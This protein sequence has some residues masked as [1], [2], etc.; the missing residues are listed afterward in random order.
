MKI[1]KIFALALL[2]EILLIIIFFT[3]CITVGFTIVDK[4]LEEEW[5]IHKP[6]NLTYRSDIV[7]SKNY[8]TITVGNTKYVPYREYNTEEYIPADVKLYGAINEGETVDDNI[9]SEDFDIVYTSEICPDYIWLM[10]SKTIENKSVFI[11]PGYL[12]MYVKKEIK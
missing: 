12:Q 3:A 10:S 6:E 5:S 1:L 7:I 11:S 8:D 4:A 9:E 2:A